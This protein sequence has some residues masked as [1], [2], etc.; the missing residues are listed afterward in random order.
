MKKT[1]LVAFIISAGLITT[2][3][4]ARSTRRMKATTAQINIKDLPEFGLSLIGPADSSYNDL[5]S[6]IF[7]G[8]Q[9]VVVQSLSPYSV[10]LKNTSGR[11]VVACQIKWEFMDFNGEVRTE[12][13]GFTT[14]WKLMNQGASGVGGE[15]IQPHSTWFL[16]PTNVAIGPTSNLSE[17]LN[18]TAKQTLSTYYDQLIAALEQSTN[19]TVSIDG[20]FFDD[21]TFVG[22][23]S[24]RFFDYVLALR[25]ARLDI[26]R[27]IERGTKQSGSANKA[28]E[29]M[30]QL[31][32]APDVGLRS[33][34]TL[35]ELYSFHKKDV[36][37]EVLRMK[38]KVGEEETVK[39]FMQYMRT[40]PV[41]LKKIDASAANVVDDATR[42][43]S[44]K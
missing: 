26:F 33:T 34:P 7:S 11:A 1:L 18:T 36:A 31:V 12:V 29:K 42:D 2:V 8:E 14:L 16:P 44:V 19:I 3:V 38:Q 35:P 30:R 27:E 10:V 41:L 21:G 40:P 6:A 5:V 24:T 39:F 23:D 28:F 13:T 4:L 43:R 9:P 32:D 37:D 15:I 17:R 22:Q 20:V 25:D